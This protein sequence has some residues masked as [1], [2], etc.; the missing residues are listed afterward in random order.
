M[1]RNVEIKARLA[2]PAATRR[3][4]ASAADGPPAA[5]AQ[6]DTF[7]RVP[8]GRLKLREI[9]GGAAELIWYERRDTPEPSPSDFTVVEVSDAPAL[10]ELLAAALGRRGR[11]AKR[12]LVYHVGR[13][14]VHL[15]QVDG[16][17]DFLEL[18]V[19]LAADE[20][21]E[22]GARE[23]RDLMARL[24]IGEA[25]LVAESYIDLLGA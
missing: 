17:G 14:R 1:A 18:E 8:R 11:V 5:L 2:D 10:R 24:G 4:V 6:T 19:Q 25:S 9:E 20:P 3:L 21:A 23:A 12:R 13:T 15:D 16:L 22:R 7:F